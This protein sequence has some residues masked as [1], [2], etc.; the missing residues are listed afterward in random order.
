M[1]QLYACLLSLQVMLI[2]ALKLLKTALTNAI[3]LLIVDKDCNKGYDNDD[4]DDDGNK[5]LIV[6]LIASFSF[7]YVF[8]YPLI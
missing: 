1:H 7:M 5:M 2:Q 4:D 6:W 8:F 3:R